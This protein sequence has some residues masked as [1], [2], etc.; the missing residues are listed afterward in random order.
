MTIIFYKSFLLKILID[1][2]SAHRTINT[3]MTNEYFISWNVS[4]PCNIFILL[5]ANC[6][7]FHFIALGNILMIKSITV[8]PAVKSKEP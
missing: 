4:I 8:K 1:N 7:G 6:K 3:I 5:F 2:P